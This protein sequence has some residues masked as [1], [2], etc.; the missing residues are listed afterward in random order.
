MFS[1]LKRLTKEVAKY[2]AIIPLS[3]INSKM[4]SFKF[5]IAL[6]LLIEISVRLFVKFPEVFLFVS[7]TDSNF[8]L[9]YG[10]NFVDQVYLLF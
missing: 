9:F 2:G 4:Y 10:D 1:G 6:L 5:S 8:F 3:F 7:V